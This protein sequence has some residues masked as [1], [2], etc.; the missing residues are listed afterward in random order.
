MERPADTPLASWGRIKKERIARSNYLAGLAQAAAGEAAAAAE[1]FGRAEPVFR[2]DA[3]FREEYARALE[4]AGGSKGAEPAVDERDAAMEA[5]RAPSPEEKIAAFEDFL[6][7]FPAGDRALEIRIRLVEELSKSPARKGEAIAVAEAA[8]AGS[9]D[10]EVLSALALLLAEAGVGTERAVVYGG[11]AVNIVEKVVRDP[12]TDAADLPAIHADL[13]LVRDAYGW[14]LLK[15]GRAREAVE[16]LKKASESEYHEVKYH[17]GAALLAAGDSF[18]ACGPLTDAALGGSEEAWAAIEKIRAGDSALRAHVDDLLGRGEEGL[19]RKK[20]AEEKAWAAPEF[21]LVSLDGN[22]V[23]AESLRGNVAVLAFWATWCEPCR[24]ELPLLQRVADSYQGKGVRFLGVNT[25]RD[26]WV[27]RP[28]LD[29]LGVRI[30]T[31]LTVGEADWEE[32]ARA[33]RVGAIPALLVIDR[34]GNVRYTESGYDGSGRMFE[35]ALS[36]RID[37]LLSGK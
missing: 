7:R 26:M 3:R 23:S 12:A 1:S 35:K 2:S 20:L 37:E 22:V 6:R 29:D 27:V 18:G 33:F 9:E 13:L 28:F 25:D 8:A 4:A 36:W 5:M 16:Q 10:P 14:A 30:E 24:E 34:E 17:Y 31:V 15:D 32:K 11:R 19:R 21:S